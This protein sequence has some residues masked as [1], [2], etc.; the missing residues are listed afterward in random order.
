M[1]IER[2]EVPHFIDK[3]G[4]LV[5]VGDFIAYGHNLGRCAGIRFG[6][7]LKIETELNYREQVEWRIRVQ[8]IDDDWN[9]DINSAK[10]AGKGTLMFP[11]RILGINMLI[12][13]SYKALFEVA[14]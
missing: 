6:K 3:S 1:S 7:V 10:L 13:D 2:K 9:T 14:E 11:E 5:S 12:P 4:R 8:G